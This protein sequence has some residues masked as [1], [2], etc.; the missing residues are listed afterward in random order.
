MG[1]QIFKPKM[2]PPRAQNTSLV[3]FFRNVL[4][5]P[6]SSIRKSAI[7]RIVAGSRFPIMRISANSNPKSIRLQQC[8]KEPVKNTSCPNC[9]EKCSGSPSPFSP[10]VKLFKDSLLLLIEKLP[11]REFFHPQVQTGIFP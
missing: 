7:I 9:M 8:C 1:H 3:Y 6:A 2:N 10:K 4:R 5:L 11:S